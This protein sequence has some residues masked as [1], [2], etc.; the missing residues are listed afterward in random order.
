MNYSIVK[1]KA[2]GAMCTD[3]NTHDLVIA[4]I[5]TFENVNIAIAY[6]ESIFDAHH[7][8]HGVCILDEKKKDYSEF[9][10]ASDDEIKSEFE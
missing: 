6:A 4:K 5:G 1:F 8:R 9:I 3:E 10:V 7:V 2:G